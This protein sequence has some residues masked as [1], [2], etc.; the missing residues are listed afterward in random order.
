MA[1]TRDFR[2]TVWAS[3]QRDK[4]FRIAL[5][6]EATE[7]LLAGDTA[8]GKAILRDYVNATLGFEALANEG[9]SNE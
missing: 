4:K 6:S 9:R 7:A 1:L 5:L 3:A 8:T 2:E